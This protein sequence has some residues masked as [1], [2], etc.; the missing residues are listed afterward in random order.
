M[1]DSAGNELKPGDIVTMEARVISGE[2]KDV[3]V[4]PL[5]FSDHIFTTSEFVTKKAEPEPA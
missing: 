1:T 2:G 4:E 5:C 3:V